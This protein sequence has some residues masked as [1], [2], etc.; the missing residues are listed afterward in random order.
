MPSGTK[1]ENSL[2]LDKYGKWRNIWKIEEKNELRK[3][4]DKRILK[5]QSR[6]SKVLKANDFGNGF[7]ALTK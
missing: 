6:G 1:W 2:K 7:E 5:V 4:I 3:K